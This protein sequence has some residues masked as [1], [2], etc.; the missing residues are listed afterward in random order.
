MFC[1]LGAAT[2]T[3]GPYTWRG[4]TSANYPFVVS[5]VPHASITV[6]EP[7]YGDPPSSVTLVDSQG[8]L[9]GV[10]TRVSNFSGG[11]LYLSLIHISEP[12]RPY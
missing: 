2:V 6:E 8:N 7:I 9:L 12:T 11:G 4:V 1:Q 3:Y 10:M 5:C